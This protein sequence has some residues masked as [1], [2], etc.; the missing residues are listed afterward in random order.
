MEP[1]SDNQR[2][3]LNKIETAGTRKIE[4][5]WKLITSLQLE[6]KTKQIRIRKSTVAKNK[7]SY[8]I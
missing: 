2:Y 3:D 7:A 1:N 8:Y 6:I 5:A 4:R